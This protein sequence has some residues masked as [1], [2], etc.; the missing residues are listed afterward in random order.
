MTQQTEATSIEQKQKTGSRILIRLT[1]AAVLIIALI[2]IG[3]V[4]RLARQ[5]EARILSMY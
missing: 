3:T 4:P 1:G 5:R 2:A